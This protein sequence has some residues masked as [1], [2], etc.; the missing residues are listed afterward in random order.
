VAYKAII[1][2]C[3]GVLVDSEIVGLDDT[4]AYLRR[5]GFD[6]DARYLVSTFTGMR[7]DVFAAKI[8]EE[9]SRVLGREAS[10]TEA[11]AL[12]DGM[13]ETRRAKRDTL[14]AVAGA[15]ET[16]RAVRALAGIRTAVASS[17]RMI[18]LESKLKRTGL[19]D[20]FA[21]DVYSAEAVA[22]G[23]PAPDI[24]LYTADKIDV[25]PGACLVIEDAA[26]G[27]TAARAAGMEVWGFT[28]G[29]HCFEGHGE[30]LAE[31]GAGRV[32]ADHAALVAALATTG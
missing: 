28:G 5:H 24:F 18:Y 19:W 10:A 8:H 2:D 20:F 6:W 12:F 9:Y 30:R 27:V 17:S 15:A 21:P 22:H 13:V 31:A 25:E 23:K 4:I 1:F 3:D 26:H 16:A 7:D 14:T 11:R 32:I 29:G